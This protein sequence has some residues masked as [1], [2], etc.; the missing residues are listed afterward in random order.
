MEGFDALPAIATLLTDQKASWGHFRPQAMGRFQMGVQDG[1]KIRIANLTL[2]RQYPI[3]S[4]HNLN[5]PKYH[6][7]AEPEDSL[8][9]N[10]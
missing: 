5:G 4:R 3:E 10:Q 6:R 7:R 9:S 2:W 8:S 1:L